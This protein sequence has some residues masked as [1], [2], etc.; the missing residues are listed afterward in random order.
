MSASPLIDCVVLNWRDADR[1]LRCLQSLLSSLEIRSVF[2]VDNES[3]GELRSRVAQ[4]ADGRVDL[5]ESP[6]NLGFAGGVNIG[7]KAALHAGADQVLCINNDAVLQPG[8]LKLLSAALTEAPAC[9]LVGPKVT[10]LRGTA[11]STGG[12]FNALWAKTSDLASGKPDYITWACVLVSRETLVNVGILDE[13]FFMYWE[14]V[15]FGL[16]ARDAGFAP[17]VVDEALALHEVSSS[18]SRAGSRISSYSTAGLVVLL[19]KRRGLMLIGAPCRVAGRVI[20]ALSR[21]DWGTARA[22]LRGSRIGLRLDGP[23]YVKFQAGAQ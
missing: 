9:G 4:M 3:D 22:H 15:D 20:R 16:R 23:A 7:L 8:S 1:T 13:R 18:H 5:I 12:S 10:D 11:L 21:G 19:R 2:L 14:D 6:Q 17:R